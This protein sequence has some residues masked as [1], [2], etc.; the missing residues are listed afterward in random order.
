MHSMIRQTVGQYLEDIFMCVLKLYENYTNR[1][2]FLVDVSLNH[3]QSA[4]D[5]EVASIDYIIIHNLLHIAK[6][7]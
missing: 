2:K 7:S 6:Q 3:H 5:T 4:K 1:R